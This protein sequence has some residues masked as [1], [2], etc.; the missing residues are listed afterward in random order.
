MNFTTEEVLQQ[1]AVE[2]DEVFVN[3][4][5]GIGQTKYIALVKDDAEIWVEDKCYPV[6]EKYK[7]FWMMKYAY[8]L[9]HTDFREALREYE[10]VKCVQ[11][12]VVHI[13]YVEE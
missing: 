12:E 3:M 4:R 8:N 7:G 9:Q 1:V 2:F 5:K 6:P 10:W 11:K 13:E